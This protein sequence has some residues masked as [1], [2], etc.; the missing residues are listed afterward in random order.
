VTGDV[1]IGQWLER[2]GRVVGDEICD[3]IEKLIASHLREICRDPTGWYT[4]FRDRR[5]GQLWERSY[6]HSNWHGGGPP[7][8]ERISLEAARVRFG[9]I[10]A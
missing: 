3:V 10:P 8:L 7:K 6:P 9:D 5:D 1:L 4:L 2:D